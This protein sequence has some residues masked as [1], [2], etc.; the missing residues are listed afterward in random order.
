MRGQGHGSCRTFREP[1]SKNFRVVLDHGLDARLV[2]HVLD[3]F[4]GGFVSHTIRLGLVSLLASKEIQHIDAMYPVIISRM[5]NQCDVLSNVVRERLTQSSA[6]TCCIRG[7]VDGGIVGP[8][9]GRLDSFAKLHQA[10]ELFLDQKTKDAVHMACVITP[11]DL[12]PTPAQV[13]KI[14]Y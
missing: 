7:V 8:R 10:K 14:N 5:S 11:T 13:I 1:L 2:V 4:L 6:L 3:E 9:V 12:P